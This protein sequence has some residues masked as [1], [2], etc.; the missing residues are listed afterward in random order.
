VM[1]C[2]SIQQVAAAR[3]ISYHPQNLFVAGFI[4]S[5]GM[6]FFEGT[7]VA[8]GQSLRFRELKPTEGGTFQPLVVTCPKRCV[9]ALQRYTGRQVVLGLR[10]QDIR[11][12]SASVASEGST[13]GVV[14]FL[15]HIG[16]ALML[17][18]WRGKVTLVAQA[19]PADRVSVGEAVTLEVDLSR[20]RFFDAKSGSAIPCES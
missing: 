15:E 10:P 2:G 5:P 7:V 18:L 12:S 11:Y 16:G 4:G 1:N 8:E 6:N 13:N 9:V 3:E 20:A 14:E 19:T 17:H